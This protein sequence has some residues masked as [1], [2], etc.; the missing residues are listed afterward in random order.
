MTKTDE[1]PANGGDGNS[2][3]TRAR[4]SPSK[5]PL[6][7][8]LISGRNRPT[9]GWRAAVAN[10]MVRLG[11]PGWMPKPSRREVKELEWNARIAKLW[12]LTDKVEKLVLSVFHFKG[13][14]GKTPVAAYLSC[15]L[16]ELTGASVAF[17]DGNPGST[18]PGMRMGMWGGIRQPTWALVDAPLP[19]MFRRTATIW[20]LYDAI[21]REDESARVSNGRVLKGVMKQNHYGVNTLVADPD[22][23]GGADKTKLSV[24]KTTVSF[25]SDQ[26]PFTFIDTGNDYT[27]ATQQA[28]AEMSTDVLFPAYVKRV[29]VLNDLAHTVAELNEQSGNKVQR[30]IVAMSGI[31]PGKK[32]GSLSDFAP[33]AGEFTVAKIMGIPYDPVIEYEPSVRLDLL[34]PETR[35]AL[36][37]ILIA[38][39]E[40]NLRA[41]NG[42]L[43]QPR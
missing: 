28:L 12:Q 16:A 38:V 33:Y 19:G 35:D 3:G 29:E 39:M 36:V 2:N 8:R 10:V 7:N 13:G 34:Q 18:S 21:N 27:T 32:G 26:F 6:G 14:A 43:S 40:Q 31:G 41:G 22:R 24:V 17:I 23:R 15:L 4:H 30:S 1:R 20:E 9:M 5:N 25:V 42:S 37:D 11:K